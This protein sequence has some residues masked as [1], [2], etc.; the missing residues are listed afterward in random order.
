MEHSA[1]FHTFRMSKGPDKNIIL[2]A[3]NQLK[4]LYWWHDFNPGNPNIIIKEL[5]GLLGLQ[6]LDVMRLLAILRGDIKIQ[7]N[8]GK[9]YIQGKTQ[10][11]TC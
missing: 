1:E 7:F 9:H 4:L 5:M 8:V 11:D 10:S 2:N 6:R 3:L